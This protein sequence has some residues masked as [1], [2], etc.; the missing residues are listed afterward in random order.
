MKL[1][2]DYSIEE[3]LRQVRRLAIHTRRKSRQQLSGEYHSAFRGSGMQFREV[4][5]YDPAD[6]MRFIDWNVSARMGTPYSKVFEEERERTLMLV[7]DMSGSTLLGSSGS[8]LQHMAQVAAT[9]AF[10]ALDNQDKTGAI[11]FTDT[12][13]LYIPPQKGRKHIMHILR[14][15]LGFVP[16]GKKSN[17]LP[18]MQLLAKAGA[19]HSIV[20]LLSDFAYDLQQ[21]LL[22]KVASAT[23]AMALH[24]EGKDGMVLPDAGL[25]PLQDAESGTTTWIDSSHAPTRA[26]WLLW[27]Q[28]R[29]HFVQDTLQKSGWSYLRCAPGED[30]IPVLQGF[31]ATKHRSG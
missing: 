9:L 11:F 23:D 14:S 13:E 8:R 16:V 7:L 30:Y 6:D 15:L 10:A 21:P 4:R 3:L 26:Q 1:Q 17:V 12:V 18:A 31:F 5:A 2:D 29:V 19:R 22:K 24:L 27:Q 20:C 28:R 25:L